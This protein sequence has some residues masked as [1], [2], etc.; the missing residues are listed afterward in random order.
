MT[1]LQA[2]LLAKLDGWRATE[3]GHPPSRPEAIRR[4][5]V[6]ALSRRRRRSGKKDGTD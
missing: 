4:L 3:P 2:D 6:Q 5:L 1:R